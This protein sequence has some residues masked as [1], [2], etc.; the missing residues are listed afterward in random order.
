MDIQPFNFDDYQDAVARFAVHL[1]YDKALMHG[2]LGLGGE[3]GEILEK[4]KKQIRDGTPVSDDDLDKELGD[5]LWYIAY[6]CTIRHLRLGD[7]ALKNYKKLADRQQRG[8][9]GGSGD[10][11]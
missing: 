1:P 3:S 9:L 10:N 4:F 7:I 11:R 2:V 8:V 6:L 5:V